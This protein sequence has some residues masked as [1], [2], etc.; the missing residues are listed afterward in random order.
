MRFLVRIKGIQPNTC[1]LQ[2][3]FCA[4]AQAKRDTETAATLADAKRLNELQ[5]ATATKEA[6]IQKLK[7]QL[8]AIAVAQKLAIN[9]AVGVVEKEGVVPPTK[10]PEAV[11]TNAVV[12]AAVW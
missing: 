11:A 5:S 12:L 10:T 3:Y 7:A 2:P 4:V 8:D 6:E 9:E 1:P